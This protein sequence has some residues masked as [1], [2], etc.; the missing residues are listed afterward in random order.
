MVFLLSDYFSFVFFNLNWLDFEV[1]ESSDMNQ[2]I[3][4]Y[5]VSFEESLQNEVSVFSFAY[6]LDEHVTS[7]V[8]PC[9]IV[10]TKT[11]DRSNK[12]VQV[13]GIWNCHNFIFLS[14]FWS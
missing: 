9:L 5:A 12:F 1:V 14:Q 4:V 3:C 10:N 7:L 13:V 8:F 2:L 11:V 6:V